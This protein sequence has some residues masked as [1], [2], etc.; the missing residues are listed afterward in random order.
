MPIVIASALGIRPR[1]SRLS[2]CEWPCRD[3]GRKL[4]GCTADIGFQPGQLAARPST[5]QKST[6]FSAKTQAFLKDSAK[7]EQARQSSVAGIHFE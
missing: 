5:S 2:L 3:D 6:P 4:P 1:R 7:L